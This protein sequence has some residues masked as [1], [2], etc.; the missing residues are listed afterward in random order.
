MPTRHEAE[1]ERQVAEALRGQWRMF[2]R[3]SVR[4]RRDGEGFEAMIELN[5]T[6][7]RGSAEQRCD[8]PSAATTARLEAQRLDAIVACVDRANEQLSA[9][10]SIRDFVVLG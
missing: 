3:V 9:P 10:D 7:V 4:R 2:E 8:R 6:L 5:P 1:R